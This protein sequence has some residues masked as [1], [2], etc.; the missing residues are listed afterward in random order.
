MS[1]DYVIMPQADDDEN[2]RWLRISD[3]RIVRR[4]RGTAWLPPAD[5]DDE[6]ETAGRVLLVL[7]ASLTTLHWI[8]C[9]GMTRR[10]GDAAARLIAM[11]ASIGDA[12]LLHSAAAS[13]EEPDKPH[14]VA[15]TSRAAM[16]YWLEWCTRN[17]VSQAALVPAAALLPAPEDG[18]VLGAFGAN[19]VMRGA[20]F[21]LDGSEPY[22]ALLTEDHKIA[23]LTPDAADAVLLSALHDP[24]IDLRQG[25]YTRRAPALFTAARLRRLALLGVAIVV[26]GLIISLVTVIRLNAEASRLNR[27]TVELAK[28]VDPSV[29]DAADAEPKVAALLA[30]RGGSGGFTGTMAGLM[31]AMQTSSAVSMTSASQLADGSLR[32]RLSAAKAD[33][34]NAVLLSIQEA[35]WRISANSV[36]QQGAVLIADITVVRS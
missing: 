34:I 31:T 15:V 21:A 5:D 35:G 3:G 30:Q 7:P 22:S 27:Q 20:D 9:P 14:M 25:E 36:Q 16:D 10:Q 1:V 11:E 24:P 28:T 13:E 19:T 6:G 26:V 32:V 29:V 23:E 12:G 2:C 4:G 18:L 33:D 17:G 8:A